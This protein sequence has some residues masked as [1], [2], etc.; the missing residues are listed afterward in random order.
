MI[1][2]ISGNQSFEIEN[3]TMDEVIQVVQDQ[4]EAEKFENIVVVL[5]SS[6]EKVVVIKENNEITIDK[7]SKV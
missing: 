4:M 2:V 1:K 6:E 5:T 3:K 7:L